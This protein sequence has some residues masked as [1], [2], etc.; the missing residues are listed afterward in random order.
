[1]LNRRTFLG[2]LGAPAVLGP[3]ALEPRALSIARELAAT[4]GEP[5]QI[6]RDEDY[7]SRVQTAFAVDRSMVNFNNGGVCPSP[8][9]VQEAFR[10]HTQ[11][12]NEA[13]AYKMWRI[14]EPQK[15]TVRALLA[16][17]LGAD[18][19]EVAITRNASEG[20]QICQFG[21]DLE[22]GDEVLCNDQ[23]YPRMITT[24]QQ[25]VRREGI[26]LR[27]FPIPVPLSDPS[28]VVRRYAERITERTRLILISHM[29]NLTGQVLPVKEV[30]ELGRRRGIPVIVDGAHTFAHF[31]FRR[32]DLDCDYYASSLHKW[33]FA[34]FGTG[35][36]Y[37]RRERIGDLWPLMAA[38]QTQRE[39]IRKFE[40]IGT[41]SVP[42]ILSI[43][44]ALTFHEAMGPERKAARMAYLRDRWA[45][46]LAAEDRVRMNTHLAE[47]Q[48][49]GIA[50]VG[51][52]GIDTTELQKHLWERH[53][54]YTITIRFLGVDSDGQARPADAAPH[55][56]GL[57]VSP[58]P[59]AT[60]GEVDRFAD[61]VEDVLANG[62][63][64]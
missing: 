51:L 55:F 31:P 56:E 63:A 38:P 43:A 10:R 3:A 59:Y 5:A 42:L 62:L 64:G 23:D 44:D 2:A 32:D 15:E 25:R 48:A 8:T 61:A 39:D 4:P 46:R 7:W 37:V 36:L 18:A 40:E 30:V 9:P 52:E 28:E 35:V 1:M 6:A 13:P 29:I 53:R 33:L 57:R 47:G 54:I 24:F 22:P 17:H 19:E 34:P 14:Q 26:V 12:A 60:L 58:A 49:Y 41:H 45:K 21:F 27:R 50:N 11:F 20:L 16:R